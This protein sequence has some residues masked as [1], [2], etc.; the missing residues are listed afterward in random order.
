MA[1][2]MVIIGPRVPTMPVCAGPILASAS[3]IIKLGN[4]VLNKA[5][6][7]IQNQADKETLKVLKS[8]NNA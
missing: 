2:I 8:I 3:L 1:K 7:M 4:T 6:Q 5:K